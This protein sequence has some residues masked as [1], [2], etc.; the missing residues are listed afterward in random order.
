MINSGTVRI[1][2]DHVVDTIVLGE[3][4]NLRIFG[5]GS[6]SLENDNHNAHT[7]PPLSPNG[8]IRDHSIVNGVPLSNVAPRTSTAAQIPADPAR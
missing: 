5:P 6:L 1:D 3:D 8:T 7:C 2:D 4:A